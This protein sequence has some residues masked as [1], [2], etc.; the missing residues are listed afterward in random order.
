MGEKDGVILSGNFHLRIEFQKEY[1]DRLP[2]VYEEENLIPK[3][4]HKNPDTSLCLGT[5]AELYV[6]FSKSPC[7][8]TFMMDIVNPY[9]FRWLATSKGVSLWEDRSHGVDGII[10]G[11]C[12]LISL[13]NVTQVHDSLL[14]MLTHRDYRSNSLCPC[15]SRIKTKLC[16]RKKFEWISKRVPR[17]I[18]YEDLKLIKLHLRKEK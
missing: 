18:L 2:V 6:L 12:T 3:H 1:P 5:P 10:E 15:G 7:L 9:L 4:Y 17:E 8:K 14:F 13:K 16:H 11:Y